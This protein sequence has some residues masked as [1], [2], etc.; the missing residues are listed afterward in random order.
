MWNTSLRSRLTIICM[1]LAICPLLL[2]GVVLTQRS[3]TVQR[4]QALALQQQVAHQVAAKVDRFIREREH[5]LRLIAEVRGLSQLDKEQQ[6]GLLAE[7][8]AYQDVYDELILLDNQGQEQLY[9]SRLNV[10]SAAELGTRSGAEE[11]EKPEAN[12]ETY[13]SSV[14]FDDATG[15]PFMTIAI[16][17]F[18]LQSG[19]LNG[20]LVADFRFKTVWNLLAAVPLKSTE[21]IYIVDQNHRV[22]AHRSPTV[23]LKETYFP[24]PGHEDEGIHTGLGGKNV[25][26]AVEALRLGEQTLTIVAEKPVSEALELAITTVYVVTIV[27]L[28]TLVVAGGLGGLAARQIVRPI[29]DLATIAHAVT[30]GD[31]SQKAIVVNRDEV[32]ELANAFNTMTAQLHSMISKL[33]HHVIEL[34]RAEEKLNKMNENLQR[35]NRELQQFAYIASHDLQEPLRMVAS[36]TRLLEKRYKNQLDEKADTYIHYA[37]EGAT[38]MQALIIDLLAYSRVNTQAKSVQCVESQVILN[39]ALSNLK[40]AIL[41]SGAQVTHDDLPEVNVDASQLARVF[42]NLIGNAIKF[43][44]ETPPRIHVSAQSTGDEW[45]FSVQDN[46]I[47]IDPKHQERIFAIFQ[48]LHTRKEYPGTG[49]GLAICKRIIN[50]HGGKIRVE[51]EPGKGAVFYFTLAKVT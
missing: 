38:R 3:F 10:I 32:G 24:L 43:R 18:D 45:L 22:V 1:S 25:A 37:V 31:Y 13:F 33:E 11:F 36:Y 16:P 2:V 5:E 35:S 9:L 6:R 41:E 47:G 46:G 15:E 17:L 21:D 19:L 48:R 7:L 50:R 20:V 12:A 27:I 39:N 42:Q 26:F 28:I 14:R 4:A 40:A 8:L 29:E 34:K 49:I 30:M 51:S 44:G 23:V